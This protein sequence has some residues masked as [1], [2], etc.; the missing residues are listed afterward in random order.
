[1]CW[2]TGA[3]NMNSG[4]RCGNSFLNGNTGWER[5]VYHAD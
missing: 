4:Y 5:V 2:H 1:M 3:G